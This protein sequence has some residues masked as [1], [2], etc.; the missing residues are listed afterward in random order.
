MLISP[1]LA[2]S[3]WIFTATQQRLWAVPRLVGVTTND[4][5]Y[6]ASMVLLIG[7]SI[8]ELSRRAT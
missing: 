8:I 2:L 3:V 4:D 7:A 6:T 5:D 1:N